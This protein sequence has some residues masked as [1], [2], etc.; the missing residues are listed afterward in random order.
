MFEFVIGIVLVIVGWLQFAYGKL[1]RFKKEARTAWIR[2]E[3]LVKA[4]AEALLDLLE[5]LDEKGVQEP[6]MA[7]IYEMN[8]GYRPSQDREDISELAEEVTPFAYSLFKKCRE[9]GLLEDEI[10][11]IKE[12]DEELRKMGESYNRSIYNHNDIIGWKKYRLQILVLKP[13]ILKD[14]VL[15]RKVQ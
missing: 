8:G 13:Q 12:M 15:D 4:R 2:I 3:V 10:R 1:M 7:E 9:A 14:F 5:M 6:E 11:E